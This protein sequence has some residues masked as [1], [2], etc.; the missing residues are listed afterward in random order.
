MGIS[1]IIMAS[2]DEKA[3]HGLSFLILLIQIV[4]SS[5]ND[6]L[7]VG[8]VR[9]AGNDTFLVE[10]RAIGFEKAGVGLYQDAAG[11]CGLEIFP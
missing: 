7:Q 6:L 5:L 1:L 9:F 4:E 11:N 8:K 3:A 2:L 10:G